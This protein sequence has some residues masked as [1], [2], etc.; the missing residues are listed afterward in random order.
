ML[1]VRMACGHDG[2]G[3][4]RDG[5]IYCSACLGDTIDALTPVE[6][7]N[8][9][10]WAECM[11]CGAMAFSEPSKLPFFVYRD[12]QEDDRYWCGCGNA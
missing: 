2:D 9:D 10:R 6:I 3:L 5:Q 8:I 4:T 12:G 1:T 7:P 11:D